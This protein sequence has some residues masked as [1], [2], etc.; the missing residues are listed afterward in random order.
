MK[1]NPQWASIYFYMADGHT[2]T[3]YE[4]YRK[5]KCTRLPDR[6]LDVERIMKTKV[7]RK[8]IQKNGKRYLAYGPL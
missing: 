5:F 1:N 6:I 8:W 7:P 2:I 3:T 4:S